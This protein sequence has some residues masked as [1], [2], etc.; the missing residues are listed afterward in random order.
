[1]WF[2]SPWLQIQFS[3]P[4]S[5][6]RL[7]AMTN[8]NAAAIWYARAPSAQRRRRRT[9]FVHISHF[10]ACYAK[11]SGKKHPCKKLLI[12]EKIQKWQLTREIK[13]YLDEDML[14]RPESSP[15]HFPTPWKEMKTW[16]IHICTSF[17]HPRAPQYMNC[18][19]RLLHI[20]WV[21]LSLT[22]E[23]NCLT[24]FITRV[25]WQAFKFH[26]RSC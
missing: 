4:M 7:N 9:T 12:R 5:R 20:L 14:K 17:N 1:M 13:I 16:A 19:K 23:V 26:K 18:T 2:I 8:A 10:A 21:S 25:D 11:C 6:I 22:K 15:I 24:S 3:I